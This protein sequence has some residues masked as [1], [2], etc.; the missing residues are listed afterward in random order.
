MRFARLFPFLTLLALRHCACLRFVA[1]S[2]FASQGA[3]LH[4]FFSASIKL[5]SDYAAGVVV[6]F[7]VSNTTPSLLITND[8]YENSEL[9]CYVFMVDVEWGRVREDAR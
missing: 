9:Q 2:G 5:P 6:A 1:G 4:G 8:V 3:H 7:Y